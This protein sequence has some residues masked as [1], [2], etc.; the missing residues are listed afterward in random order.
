MT[1]QE[2][3][4]WATVIVLTAGVLVM[5]SYMLFSGEGSRAGSPSGNGPSPA[6]AT[7]QDKAITED[8]WVRELKK[9]YG[10]EM[11]MTILNR[12]AVA[13]EAE[14]RGIDV[15]KSELEAEIDMMSRTYGSKERF[16]AEMEHQ[17][18]I[19]EE[20][21]RIETT[22]RLLL[23][24]IA[25][26]DVHI[27]EQQIDSY[28]EQYP[29]QFRPKKQLN[30]SMI[31]VASEAEANQVMDRLEAGEDFADLAAEVSLDEYTRGDGGKIGLVEED[32]P[33]VPSELMEAALTLEAGDIAGP[34]ELED[35]YAIVYVEEIVEPKVPSEESIRESVRKQLALEQSISLTE[36]EQQLREKYEARIVASTVTL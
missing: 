18:G 3:G 29:D 20:E 30:L 35:N 14:A 1:R 28:L 27:D 4:L 22:Y 32:D 2:K 5:G 36:L 12:K 9:R 23:E 8:E 21:L 10:H 6:V 16:F 34:I 15:T 13:L 17:L 24:K 25:T 11:L 31:E 7:I 33:F 19:S 26:A